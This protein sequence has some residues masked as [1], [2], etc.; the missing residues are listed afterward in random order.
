MRL[1]VINISKAMRQFVLLFSLILLLASCNRE[2]LTPETGPSPAQPVAYA[3][4]AYG[5][6][7]LQKMDIYLPGGRTVSTTK[8][9]VV[10]HGGAWLDGDKADMTFVVDSLKKR[11]PGYAF[12]NLNYRLAVN[13]TTSLFPAQETDVKTAIEAYL[14]KSSTY[15]ISKDI[16]VLGASAGAHLALLHS[17]KNDPDKHVKAVID[18]FGPTDLVAIWNEGFLQQLALIAVTGKTYDQ[19]QAIYNQSSPI[20]FVTAQSPPTI[21][22]QGGLDDIVLPVQSDMLISKLNSRG[23]YNQL[24]PYPSEGH[25]FTTANNTDAMLK[26]LA[27]IAKYVK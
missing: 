5:T 11:L 19:D 18:F 26:S 4:L 15:T 13:G 8:T 3:D 22:L 6:Q 10:I 2:S 20:N 9:I 14:S 21:V 1:N 16:V 25:G 24:V 12:I 7:D 17:Y 23:V 27:F